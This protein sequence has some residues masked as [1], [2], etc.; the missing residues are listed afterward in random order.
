MLKLKCGYNHLWRL[1]VYRRCVRADN[2]EHIDRGT[3]SYR[4]KLGRSDNRGPPP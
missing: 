4:D 2:A 3:V 1:P